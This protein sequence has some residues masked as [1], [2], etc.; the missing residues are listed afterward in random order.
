MKTIETKQLWIGKSNARIAL[1]CML[2]LCFLVSTHV[3]AQVNFPGG[4]I[5]MSYDGNENDLDDYGA[6]PLA[7]AMVAKAG[8]ADKLVHIE[9]GNTICEN[10]AN[11]SNRMNQL[12][13]G[14]LQRFGPFPNVKE[15]QVRG[16][17]RNAASDN[18]AA[19]INASSANDPLW[20]IAAGPMTTVAEG[21]RKAQVGKRQHVIVISHSKWNENYDRC[22]N[23]TDWAEMKN[24]FNGDGVHFIGNEGDE[25]TV[26]P[27]NVNKLANQNKSNGDN[28]FNA[29]DNKWAWLRDSS[30]PDYRWLWENDEKNGYDVSDAGMTYFLITGGINL[31]RTQKSGCETCGSTETEQLFAGSGCQA[32]QDITD[33]STSVTPGCAI[34]LTWSDVSN[35]TTYRVRRKTASTSFII[36][37]DLAANTTSYV[38]NTAQEG[39]TY[40]YQVRPQN[41][42]SNQVSNQPNETIPTG[43]GTSGGPSDINDLAP[44]SVACDAVT[45]TWSDVSGETAYRVRRRLTSAATFTTLTDVGANVTT[46][47]DNSVA[48]ST[49]YIYQVRPVVSGTA[50]ATSNQPQVDTPPCGSTGGGVVFIDHNSSGQR[51]KANSSGGAVGTKAATSTGTNVQWDQ[52]DAGGGYFYL[53]HVGSGNKLNAT[54]NGDVINTVSATS[55]ANSA[56]WRWIDA[57]AGWFR[58]ENRQFTEWLHVKPDGVTDFALGPITWTGD[59]TRWTFTNVSGVAGGRTNGEKIQGVEDEAE[60]AGRAVLYPNPGSDE[61][62]L[63]G[64]A[65]DAE[66]RL[67][68]QGGIEVMRFIGDKA[69]I[70]ALPSGMYFVRSNNEYFGR[71]I[72]E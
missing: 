24:E 7:I 66:V 72:K 67:F 45:L 2:V 68:N 63:R 31:A 12:C 30:N 36:L 35:E 15:Y 33:L 38:D 70:R 40:T 51:L 32:T 20:I 5:A 34:E 61:L 42:C 27:N 60:I 50:V 43:C 62:I 64:I 14:A 19:E 4:R 53:V 29:P 69:D 25:G 21:I 46:Y 28:D 56:Q 11:R 17:E 18:L 22:N 23:H 54:T 6:M 49:S 57:G 26:R 39:V 16:G 8:L 59:N 10:N 9:H 1:T 13:E 47:T 48:E 52:V 71:F 55:T 3:L 41:S 44:S 37:T 65:K 58:L